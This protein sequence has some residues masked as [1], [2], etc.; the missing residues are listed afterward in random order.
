MDNRDLRTGSGYETPVTTPV[1]SLDEDPLQKPVQKPDEAPPQKP[2]SKSCYAFVLPCLWLILGGYGFGWMI[3]IYPLLVCFFGACY[4]HSNKDLQILESNLHVEEEALKEHT[5][6]KENEAKEIRDSA[7]S[8]SQD[9]VVSVEA[10]RDF[11]S[12]WERVETPNPNP[13]RQ[14]LYNFFESMR[15]NPHLLRDD[16]YLKR[17]ANYVKILLKYECMIDVS[18][19]DRDHKNVVKKNR[20]MMETFDAKRDAEIQKASERVQF[21]KDLLFVASLGL[22]GC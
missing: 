3:L 6:E 7:K 14:Y 21:W 12:L 9:L 8:E 13:W 20:Q 17:V 5:Q 11:F 1:Q 15:N 10:V 2:G 22:T 4:L 18:K 19:A 16:E